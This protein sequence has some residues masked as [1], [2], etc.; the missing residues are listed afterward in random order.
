MHQVRA[1]LSEVWYP[2]HTLVSLGESGRLMPLSETT[3]PLS[4]ALPYVLCRLRR[5]D[6]R[7]VWQGRSAWRTP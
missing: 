5:S 3:D 1:R 4:S 6:L 2:Q 7:L